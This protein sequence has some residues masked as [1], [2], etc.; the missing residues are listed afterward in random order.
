MLEFPAFS[1]KVGLDASVPGRIALDGAA[2]QDLRDNR[3]SVRIDGGKLEWKEQTFLNLPTFTVEF[4]AKL[5]SLDSSA[6][7]I[8]MT[9]GASADGNPLWA[10]YEIDVQSGKRSVRLA[11]YDGTTYNHHDVVVNS[12]LADGRWHHWALTFDG[13]SGTQTVVKFYRDYTQI[14]TCTASHLIN[15]PSGVHTL[16]IGGTSNNPCHIHGNYDELRVSEGVLPTSAF[17]RALP[18]CTMVIVR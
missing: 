6:N 3:K 2:M 5:E 13:S 15:Y 18:N 17:L 8:R 11:T 7:L 12:T 1:W 14:G 10:L 16:S 4:F 9:H